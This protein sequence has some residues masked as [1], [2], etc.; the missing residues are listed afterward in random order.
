MS[1]I[2]QGV[3]ASIG[4]ISG[5]QQVYASAGSYS[6][7]VPAGVTTICAVAVGGGGAGDD[8]NAGDGGG[9]GGGGGG[10]AYANDIPVTPGNSYAVVVGA[11]GPAGASAYGSKAQNGNPSSFTVGSFAM[12]GNGGEGG[13]PYPTNPGS[14][15]GTYSFSSTPGGV[16][17]GG[18]NGG[19]GGGGYDGGGG[20]GGA[21][22][23]TGVG[24]T[25]AFS[26]STGSA[27]VGYELSFTRWFGW[28]SWW[29]RRWVMGQCHRCNFCWWDWCSS[30]YLGGRSCVPVN[31]H[32]RCVNNKGFYLWL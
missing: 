28:V 5:G 27:G 1:G 3:L 16:T 9:G 15:G 4:G 7:L 29:W 26:L 25:G 6:F 13:Y 21:G 32:G 14:S 18:G 2:L 20:G 23:F 12:T 30:Y 31:K 11:G 22:G 19:G 8:G 10:L 17:T 24:G